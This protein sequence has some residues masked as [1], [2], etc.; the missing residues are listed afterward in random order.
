LCSPSLKIHRIL[1][2]FVSPI[3]NAAKYMVNF[4]LAQGIRICAHARFFDLHERS[5]E[6]ALARATT[7]PTWKNLHTFPFLF[8]LANLF[9]AALCS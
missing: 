1:E 2:T 4:P 9:A 3:H 8:P 6:S 5:R 7:P